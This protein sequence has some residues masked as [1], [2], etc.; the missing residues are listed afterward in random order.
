MKKTILLLA[1]LSAS[2][3]SQ[4]QKVSYDDNFVSPK[5]QCNSYLGM[6][7][8]KG[9]MSNVPRCEYPV[10]M[11]LKKKVGLGWK[12]NLKQRCNSHLKPEYKD[13][14]KIT[15]PQPTPATGNVFSYYL[16]SGIILFVFFILSQVLKVSI[17]LRD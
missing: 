15:T 8:H 12:T 11:F 17:T 7:S 16:F 10:K 5:T 9:D 4:A 2:T 14:I 1:L 13:F 6:S 3:I